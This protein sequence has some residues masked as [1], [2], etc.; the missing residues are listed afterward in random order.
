MPSKK[1][2]PKLVNMS[3]AMPSYAEEGQPNPIRWTNLKHIGNNEFEPVTS[4]W[5]CKDF[6][7]DAVCA[8]HN[9][10]TYQI[11]GFK[12]DPKTFYNYEWQGMPI[13]LTHCYPEFIGNIDSVINPYLKAEGMPLL[14]FFEV[15]QGLF[16]NLDPIYMKN[17][18]YISKIT[19][20]IRM[21]NVQKVCKTMAE[22]AAVPL[23]LHDKPY[24]AEAMKKPFSKFN[25][26]KYDDYLYYYKGTVSNG[27]TLKK[28]EKLQ[29]VS[30][31][32][33]CGVVSWAFQTA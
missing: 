16:I 13:L 30:M 7:N 8:Y 24:H 4:P 10:E 15:P 28:G 9:K 25:T 3:K 26:K 17:T 22:L 20:L 27:T 21:A 5:K 14:Q 12:C 29:S 31:M 33:N 23:N 32:H 6:L 11:Y 1:F 2:T 18:Y 19:L